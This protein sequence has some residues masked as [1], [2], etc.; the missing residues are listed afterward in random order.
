MTKS[1]IFFIL[2][3]FSGCISTA[4][5]TTKNS[6]TFNAIKNVFASSPSQE[7]IF[8]VF[9]EPDSK[10]N[11]GEKEMWR[12]FDPAT[13][14]ERIQLTFNNAK[15]LTQL[16]WIPLPEEKE[17]NIEGIFAHYPSG[18]FK[19]IDKRR[20]SNHSLKTDTTYS[21][22]ISMS[23]LND[24]SSKKVQAVAWFASPQKLPN[25]PN[26]MTSR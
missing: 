23:I 13:K 24:D 11:D 15:I 18:H 6:R 2:I 3:L 4:T 12:Y 5:K 26:P 14:N 21:D 17:K 7:Q 25:N 16:L 19:A 22:G 8:K 1:S 10:E 20:V 9:G